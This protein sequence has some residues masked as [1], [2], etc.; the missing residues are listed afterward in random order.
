MLIASCLC[1]ATF[2]YD[3]GGR[4]VQ[5]QSPTDTVRFVWD[6][7]KVLQEADGTGATEQQYLSTDRQY[8][9]LVSGFGGGSTRYHDFDALGSTEL[10]LDDTGSVA[11]RYAYRAFGLATQT[12]GTDASPYTWVG[13]LN[14]RKDSETSLYLMGGGSEGRYYDPQTARFL[15]KDPTEYGGGD[16]NLYRYSFNDPVNHVDPSGHRL[17]VEPVASKCFREAADSIYRGGT[18]SYAG[19]IFRDEIN[20]AYDP[21]EGK[22]GALALPAVNVPINLNRRAP[23]PMPRRRGGDNPQP[24]ESIS[25]WKPERSNA[26]TTANSSVRGLDNSDIGFLLRNLVHRK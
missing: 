9:D 12:A 23:I 6:Y 13:K 3:G 8:G 5:K 18:R 22:Q 17:L 20:T 24:H 4:R 16:S 21:W 11:D 25:C 15:S 26:S 14:Y 19:D 7:E 2:A 10:L 1:K